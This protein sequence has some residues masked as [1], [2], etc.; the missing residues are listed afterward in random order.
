MIILIFK[1]F[2]FI[3]LGLAYLCVH[4]E[5]RGPFTGITVLSFTMGVLVMGLN[6]SCLAAGAVTY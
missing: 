1:T 6:W 3:N 2:L 5:F 4:V